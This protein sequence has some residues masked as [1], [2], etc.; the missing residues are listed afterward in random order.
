[1]AEATNPLGLAVVQVIDAG[2]E[3]LFFPS[4][5]YRFR[6]HHDANGNENTKV[7]HLRERA[8]RSA[9]G[10]WVDMKAYGFLDGSLEIVW[11]SD[12]CVNRP[13]KNGSK[14]DNS[15]LPHRVT[16]FKLLAR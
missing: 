4:G 11:E 10:K 6:Y 7:V 12:R 2:E 1:M 3:G 9:S 5:V 15:Y 13:R 14:F 16:G 8:T